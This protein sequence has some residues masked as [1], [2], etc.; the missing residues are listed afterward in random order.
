LTS[1]MTIKL[2]CKM[3]RPAVPLGNVP[4]KMTVSVGV[5]EGVNGFGVTVDVAVAAPT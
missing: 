5:G 3:L 1:A 4:L 2:D